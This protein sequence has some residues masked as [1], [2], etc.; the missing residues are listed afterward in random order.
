MR[1]GGDGGGEGWDVAVFEVVEEFV[2]VAGGD[3]HAHRVKSG[4]GL[5]F[6]F[7]FD[8]NVEEEDFGVVFFCGRGVCDGEG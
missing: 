2:G 1:P 3:F 8:F 5:G 4:S 6:S 7:V